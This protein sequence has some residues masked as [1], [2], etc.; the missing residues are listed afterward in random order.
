MK[1]LGYICIVILLAALLLVNKLIAEA[2][3][4]TM[5]INDYSLWAVVIS[6]LLG[7]IISFALSSIILKLIYK[8]LKY[9]VK[10]HLIK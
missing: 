2:G 9:I 6:I 1:V 10:L 5:A 3:I 8:V 4:M 7:F